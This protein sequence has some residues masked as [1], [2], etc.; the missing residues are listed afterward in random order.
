VS[1]LV[2][3]LKRPLMPLATMLCLALAGCGRAPTF[4]ILGSFFPS[5]LVCMIAGVVLAT[6]ARWVFLRLSIDSHIVWPVVVYPSLAL[7]FA[8]MLWLAFFR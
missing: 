8:C 5:W 6:L 1:E 7:L 2:I 3:V 4:D